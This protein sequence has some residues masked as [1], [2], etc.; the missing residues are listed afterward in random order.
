MKNYIKPHAIAITLETSDV[1]TMSSSDF[2][3]ALKGLWDE[4]K[5]GTVEE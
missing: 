2:G 5:T 1:I 4:F 3:S